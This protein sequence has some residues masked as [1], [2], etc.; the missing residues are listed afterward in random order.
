VLL[1]YSGRHSSSSQPQYHWIK[2]RLGKVTA[3]SVKRD[4]DRDFCQRFFAIAY[5][6]NIVYGHCLYISTGIVAH[7]TLIDNVYYVTVFL[8]FLYICANPFIY[9]TKFD[10]V[11]QIL[12]KIIRCKKAPVQSADDP[13]GTAGNRVGGRR[14]D[15]GRDLQTRD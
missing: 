12:R 4:Q 3:V 14:T 13:S 7:A 10:P 11:R 2:S 15:K 5:L 9:A 8:A 6:P 1:A